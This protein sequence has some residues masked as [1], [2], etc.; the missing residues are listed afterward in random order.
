MSKCTI[1]AHVKN[2]NGEVVESRLYKDLLSFTAN[3]RRLTKEYYAVGTNEEFLNKV[4][5]KAEFDE[6]GEITFQSLRKLAKLN[7]KETQIVSALN[8]ELGS[9]VFNYDEAIGKLSS[10]NRNS[11]YR[12][13]YMATI[14]LTN[15]G[16]YELTIVPNTKLNQI[17][18][19]KEISNRTL[20]DRIKYA[21]SRAGVAV[22]FIESDEKINGRYSTRNAQQTADG[23]YHLIQIV[24]GAKVSDALAEEAGHFAVGALGKSPLMERFLNLLTPEVQKR[25][26]GDDYD[27]KYLGDEAR[28]EVAGTLVGQALQGHIDERAPWQNLLHRIV[29]N[30]KKVFATIKGDEIMRAA[31]DAKQIAEQVASG[32]MSDTFE[33][34]VENALQTTEELYSAPVSFNV[35]TYREVLNRLKLQSA[36]MRQISDSLYDKFNNLAG[37]VETGRD[38]NSPGILGDAIALE[39][40]AE[41]ISLMADLMRS[42]IPNLL[43]SVDF[44]NVS[45]FYANMPRNAK[46]LRAVR[47]YVKNALGIIKI[48]ED[49]TSTVAEAKSLTG[50]LTQIQILDANGNPISHNLL[51]ITKSLDSLIRGRNGVLSE[52]ANK[53]SQFYLKFLEDSF[54]A[55][56]ISRAA[57]VIFKFKKGEKLIQFKDAENVPLEDVMKNLD[58]DLTLF[59][60]YIASMS[61]SSDIIGQ[62]ADRTMKYANKMADDITRNDFEELQRL[63]DRFD[64]LKKRGDLKDTRDVYEIGKDNKLTGNVLSEVNYGNYE[65]DFEE[66]RAQCKED[67][68]NNNPGLDQKSDF[69]RATLWKSYFKPLAKGWHKVHSDFFIDP[70]TQEGRYVPRMSMYKNPAWDNLSVA[71][72]AFITDIMSLKKSIDDRL[73]EG[74]TYTYRLPQFKGT[75]MDKVRNKR[76]FE[77]TAA[78]ITQTVR[79]EIRDTFCESSDDTEYGCNYTYNSEDDEIF[80]DKLAYEKEK[81]NRVPIYGINR[82][83]DTSELSTDIFHSIL[84]YAGMANNYAAVSQ[85]VDTLEVGKEVLSR[86]TVGGVYRESEIQGDKSRAFN[87]YLKF[88]DKQVYGI[89]AKKIELKV[90]RGIV[91]NKVAG[92]LSGLASKVYL[93]GN[94]AGGLVNLG[95]GF[96]EVAKEAGAG[97]NFTVKDWAKANTAYFE[98]LPHNLWDTGKQIKDD[99]VSLFIKYFNVLGENKSNWRDW[100]TRE[101]RLMNFF[102][103]SLWLPYKSGEHYM[104]TVPYIALAQSTK[105]YDEKGKAISLWDAYQVEDIA[106]TKKGKTLGLKGKTYFKSPQSVTTYNMLQDAVNQIDAVLSSTG[107]LGATL[108]LSQEQL[109]YISNAGYNLADL[110]DTKTRLQQDINSLI[111]SSDD[112]TTFQNKGRE[113]D[114]RLHGIYNDMDKVAFQQNLYGNML[115]AMRG[116]ALGMAERRFGASKYSVSLGE[117]TGGSISDF[118]KVVASTFTDRGGFKLTI[119]ALLLPFSKKTKQ[120]MLNAGFSAHQYANMRRNFADLAAIA[121][122]ALIKAATTATGGG[123]DDDDE[124]NDALGLCYYFSSRLLREQRAFNSVRGAM[125]EST[126]L[127][128]LEPIGISVLEDMW[129]IGSR[130]IGQQFVE[131]SETHLKPEEM[132]AN[133]TKY[134]YNSKKEGMYDYGDSKAQRKLLRMLPYYRSFKYTFGNPYE[135]AAAFD[136][137]RKVK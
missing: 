114:N 76:L 20:Q 71:A 11:S 91:L 77:G 23:L 56:Y 7:I 54:G 133:Y 113:I 61:N 137:G 53:E 29:D 81:L 78:A 30:I 28:R 19:Q 50:D 126:N 120:Q 83:K 99:K 21:L 38:V 67:F 74:Y 80:H 90:G 2:S 134:Y 100:S 14:K 42:E 16:Q 88:L 59:E 63:K 18:L 55:K 89:G 70:V 43:T 26:L 15:N 124:D 68:K 132:P 75:F 118:A 17:A 104:Q 117:E 129:F 112:E 47:T 94:V 108:N 92:F 79:G 27:G 25:I 119:R 106:G 72:Q 93:G 116:Y 12:K 131:P 1:L 24:N 41:S 13:S 4:R 86:R 95:T 10:F 85:V 125:D 37:Q 110:R 57:R 62:I 35:K 51:D 135:A 32:F 46:A 73:P 60:R 34:T 6:N 33:G 84:A 3:D 107:L 115:L 64:V 82:M 66:F 103:Q 65:A 8:K 9:G 105:L 69:E 102:G 5:D 39:G 111:W 121:A 128:N 122:L 45:D 136:Y 58:N 22:D 123:D 96:I 101:S 36:E 97:E 87:R 98:S 48:I 40:I 49:A 130:Y 44:N 52:L 109:D 127:F 31:I